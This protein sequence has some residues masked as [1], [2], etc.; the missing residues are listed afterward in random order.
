MQIKLFT[1]PF[2]SEETSLEELNSFL[3]H[4]KIVSVREELVAGVGWTFCVKYIQ[5]AGEGNG[6]ALQTKHGKIDYREVLSESEFNR[7]ALM[8]DARKQLAKEKSVAPYI[9]F[10]DAELAI[11]SKMETLDENT[12]KEVK[13]VGEKRCKEYG[14][15]LLER[16]QRIESEQ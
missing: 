15:L 6:A 14:M 3:L 7:F 5:S 16:M 4:N 1:I 9:I 2:G 13:G 11:F 12:M 8:R 10:T